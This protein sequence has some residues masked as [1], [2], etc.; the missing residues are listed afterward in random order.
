MLW[1]PAS[2][3]TDCGECFFSLNPVSKEGLQTQPVTL[4]DGPHLALYWSSTLYTAWGRQLM[5]Q[6]G[7]TANRSI[8]SQPE[9][10]G[11]AAHYSFWLWCTATALCNS[12]NAV[13]QDC[14]SR[15][16]CDQKSGDLEPSSS[17]SSVTLGR[18]LS[19]SEAVFSSAR[20]MEQV[21]G[22]PNQEWLG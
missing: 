14:S 15:C 5:P 11:P 10:A 20:T 19:A 9:I 22:F 21:L 4:M 8:A 18:F 1:E 12:A 16:S 3:F 13:L 7:W 6:S 17:W 2:H